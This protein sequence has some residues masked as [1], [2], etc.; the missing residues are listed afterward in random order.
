M[1]EMR[2]VGPLFDGFGSCV[3][4]PTVEVVPPVPASATYRPP[5]GLNAMPRGFV[6]P[7]A[8]TADVGVALPLGRALES[9]SERGAMSVGVDCSH[10]PSRVNGSTVSQSRVRLCMNSFLPYEGNTL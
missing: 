2:P 4:C 10:A 7:V 5:S 9:A 3:H 1:R 8:I 6:R